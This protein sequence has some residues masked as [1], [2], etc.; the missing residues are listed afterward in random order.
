MSTIVGEESETLADLLAELGD[1]SPKRIR[2]Q[3]PPGQAT[4]ED[5]IRILNREN[6]LF[7]LVD[8]VLVEKAIGFREARLASDLGRRLGNFVVANNR[9]IVTG[10]D[11]TIRLAAGLVRIPDVAFFAWTRFP[12]REMPTAPIPSLAPDLAVEVLSEG[13]TAREMERKIVEYF[14][15]GTD[16]VWI[17][18]PDGRTVQVFTSP[19]RSRVLNE[20]ETLDGGAVL[21]GF[22]LSLREFFAPPGQL[23]PKQ[24]QRSSRKNGKRNGKSNA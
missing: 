2:R 19:R 8:G 4:E 7:E 20:S 16:L 3:P 24:R 21:P 1:V 15:A 14:Q 17:I 22:T 13:N 5:V 10:P 12:K 23:R 6:R 9:G 18:D 11:G